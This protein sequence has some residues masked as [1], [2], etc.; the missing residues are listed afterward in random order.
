MDALD[1]QSA[2]V[3]CQECGT[4]WPVSYQPGR[5]SP[6]TPHEC[7]N[8]ECEAGWMSLHMFWNEADTDNAAETFERER[9]AV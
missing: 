1:I 5:T 4:R 2:H 6:M 8:R 7:K 3:V 9:Q